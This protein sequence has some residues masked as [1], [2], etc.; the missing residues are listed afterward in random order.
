[1]MQD[2]NETTIVH[3]DTHAYYNLTIEDKAAYKHM[4]ILDDEA[5]EAETL[6]GNDRGAVRIDLPFAFP[7]FDTRVNSLYITTEGFLAFGEH[8]FSMMH[9]LSIVAPLR[10]D[11][12]L[13]NVTDGKVL[14]KI[15]PSSLI[16]EWRNVLLQNARHLGKLTFQC[17]LFKSGAIVFVY[18][19]VPTNMSVVTSD[20]NHS[21]D[22]SLFG[23]VVAGISNLEPF[24]DK[25]K[26]AN[27]STPTASKYYEDNFEVDLS[28]VRN[29][30]VATFR[31]RGFCFLQND[32]GSCTKFDHCS[33]CSGK[34]ACY[35][36][37]YLSLFDIHG[38]QND[39]EA[40]VRRYYKTSVSL[41]D[42]RSWRPETDP[43]FASLKR[44]SAMFHDDLFFTFDKPFPFFGYEVQRIQQVAFGMLLLVVPQNHNGMIQYIPPSDMSGCEAKYL[45]ESRSL[46]LFWKCKDV[47]TQVVF[48][49]TGKIRLIYR[50]NNNNS[51]KNSNGSKTYLNN[52]I[53][54]EAPAKSQV[55]LYMEYEKERDLVVNNRWRKL[56]EA[57]GFKVPKLQPAKVDWPG[58]NSTVTYTPLATCL[59]QLTCRECYSFP[60]PIM[61]SWNV[62]SKKCQVK[63]GTITPEEKSCPSL[64]S[65]SSSGQNTAGLPASFSAFKADHKYYKVSIRKA[66][67][68]S[69]ALWSHIT[70]LPPIKFN[71]TGS[72]SDVSVNLSFPFPFYGHPVRH[73]I[74]SQNGMLAFPSLE[75]ES[76]LR[77]TQYIA[78][79]MAHFRSGQVYYHPQRDV[80]VFSWRN[81]QADP[82]NIFR[83]EVRKSV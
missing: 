80:A 47:S 19:N 73:V 9:M 82:H 39:C 5:V 4:V 57:F 18:S 21:L 76:I 14:Y 10:A 77:E 23:H 74:V 3:E 46:V 16:V 72:D 25:T 67:P 11:F 50:G 62:Q 48:E 36:H 1:M 7:F 78:P 40:T 51:V 61:C 53:D 66:S 44:E 68:T 49:D 65:L 27:N 69:V 6:N 45:Q 83:F 79:L 32:C 30:S 22:D 52:A 41:R 34:G 64:S 20:S 38:C 55:G 17:Q 60:G 63:D 43:R 8:L 24:T 33:W 13:T 71:G 26:M 2:I 75:F 37:S 70:L 59:D 35:G 81:L 54:V 42:T 56:D 12:T 28:L 58:V 29:G 31:P 15:T